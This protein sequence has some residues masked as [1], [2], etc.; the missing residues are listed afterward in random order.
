MT[1]LVPLNVFAGQHWVGSLTKNAS[2][3]LVFTYAPHWLAND[4]AIPLT[5]QLPLSRQ[6]F[7]GDPVETFFQNLLPEGDILDFI[8]KAWHIS[9]GNTLCWWEIGM[10]TL[11]IY[12]L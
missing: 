7:D 4:D 2:Y 9:A 3:R 8:E 12:L 6:V 5:P 11:K 1:D 10:I